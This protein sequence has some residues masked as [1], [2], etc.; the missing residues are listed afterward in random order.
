MCH[1]TEYA[2]LDASAAQDQALPHGRRLCTVGGC[3]LDFAHDGLH[4]WA[5]GAV[6]PLWPAGDRP[7]CIRCRLRPVYLAGLCGGCYA[8]TE[9]A[10]QA[11]RRALA[12]R[13]D[14]GGHLPPRT[15]GGR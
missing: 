6:D 5:Q 4:E 7:L 13:A 14:R 15:A 9:Q 10:D 3:M 12:L 2:H 11:R 8:D 1:S